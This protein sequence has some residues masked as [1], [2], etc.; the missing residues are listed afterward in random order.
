MFGYAR[1]KKKKKKKIKLKTKDN[2]Y[3]KSQGKKGSMVTWQHN[4]IYQNEMKEKENE[5]R[6]GKLIQHI[7]SH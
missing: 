1:R 4:L 7:Q 5:K 3:F 6:D 2:N